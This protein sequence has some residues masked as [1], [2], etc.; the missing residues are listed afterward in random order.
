LSQITVN[1]CLAGDGENIAIRVIGTSLSLVVTYLY[2]APSGT[3]ASSEKAFNPTRL[4]SWKLGFSP[5]LERLTVVFPACEYGLLRTTDKDMKVITDAV[6]EGQINN[7]RAATETTDADISI[8]Q[9]CLRH[10]KQTHHG[11]RVSPFGA[12]VTQ[13]VEKHLACGFTIHWDIGVVKNN[14]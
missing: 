9:R 7:L 3:L 1:D 13:T 10:F 8:H 12:F 4:A 2:S 14:G 5:L 6:R 11:I